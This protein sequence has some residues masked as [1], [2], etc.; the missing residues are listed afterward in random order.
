MLKFN[1]LVKFV[2]YNSLL[3]FRSVFFE[4]PCIYGIIMFEATDKHQAESKTLVSGVIN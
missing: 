2:M 1:C 3:K 4:T